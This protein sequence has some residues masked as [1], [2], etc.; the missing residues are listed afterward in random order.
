MQT[1]LPT[2]PGQASQGSTDGHP[3]LLLVFLWMAV[4][5]I[6]FALAII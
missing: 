1:E 2:T 4:T 5:V 6:P 3:A